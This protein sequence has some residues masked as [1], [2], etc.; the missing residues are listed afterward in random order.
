MRLQRHNSDT[1]CISRDQGS[2]AQAT[3]LVAI[4]INIVVL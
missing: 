3:N 4:K 1:A 2:L